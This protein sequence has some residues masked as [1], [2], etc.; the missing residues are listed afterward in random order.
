[1]AVALCEVPRISE[2]ALQGKRKKPGGAEMSH[3]S[4]LDQKCKECMVINKGADCPFY[5][6]CLREVRTGMHV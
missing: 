3:M 6:D 4:E 2:K 1:M 5:A